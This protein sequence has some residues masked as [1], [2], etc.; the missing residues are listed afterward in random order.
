MQKV[1]ETANDFAHEKA[2]TKQFSHEDCVEFFRSTF[3]T[4]RMYFIT[5]TK[6]RSEY[7]FFE[8]Y[9]PIGDYFV[10]DTIST[11]ENDCILKCHTHK[12]SNLT[13]EFSQ[14]ALIKIYKEDEG[15]NTHLKDIEVLQ[16]LWEKSDSHRYFARFSDESIIENEGKEKYHIVRYELNQIPVVLAKDFIDFISVD[17]RKSIALDLFHAIHILHNLSEPLYHRHLHPDNILICSQGEGFRPYVIN[18]E[19][20]KLVNSI[21][22]TVAA[23]VHE[24][25]Q[26]ENLYIA[27]ELRSQ[28]IDGNI[29]LQEW[30]K[31]DVYA[32]AVLTLFIL[33]GDE[34]TGKVSTEVLDKNEYG[35]EFITAIVRMVGSQDGRPVLAEVKD[36][37]E[38]ALSLDVPEESETASQPDKEK[39]HR[40]ANVKQMFRSIWKR[41]RLNS[42]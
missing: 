20:T 42:Y 41:S 30:E 3:H 11:E 19:Y 24:K 16:H 29:S 39:S 10:Y 7:K 32:L 2:Y 36:V 5:N 1:R 13:G 40:F 14:Y 4:I 27:P 37:F 8:D 35:K 26:S 38:K 28:N 18:F 23:Y 31:A 21:T 9:I 6:K 12:I 34:F 33:T 17:N 15:R 25:A 22:E